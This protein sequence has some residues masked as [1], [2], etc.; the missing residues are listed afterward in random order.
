M[1]KSFVLKK[2]ALSLVAVTAMFGVNSCIA[3][4]IKLFT[5]SRD[6]LKETVL[7]GHGE[8]KVLV[9]PVKGIISDMPDYGLITTRP[10]MLQEIM[11]QLKLASKDPSIKAVVL[12]VDSP[13]GTATASDVIYHEI[14]NY[15]RKSG[16]KIVVSM[17]NIATSGGYYVSLPADCIMAH[18]TTV[19]GSIGVV[20]MH[21]K[22]YGLMDK[23]GV[24]VEVNKSGKNKDMGSPFRETTPEEKKLFQKLISELAGRFTELVKKHR[25]LDQSALAEVSTAKVY[26]P[27]DAKKL[28]LIDE[29]GYLDNAILK[30]KKLAGIPQYSKVIIYRRSVYP[31]DN[32]YNTTS[33]QNDGK[34]PSLINLAPIEAMNNLQTGFYYLWTPGIK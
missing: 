17:M 30:A 34:M 2:T 29:V 28:N 21:P 27:S 33:Y 25:N 20:F 1:K 13:G 24:G 7:E 4:N 5:D 23:I 8:E 12:N 14:M 31:N 10:S 9:I 19:T 3:P 11:S 6:P 16:A 18:P 22:F 15:K 26:L 32:I